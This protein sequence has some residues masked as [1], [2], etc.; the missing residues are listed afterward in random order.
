VPVAGLVGLE[1]SYSYSLMAVGRRLVV[2]RVFCAGWLV[3]SFF[4]GTYVRAFLAC[5]VAMVCEFMASSS[6]AGWFPDPVV[7]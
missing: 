2:H 4:L 5:D 1:Y 6:C 3:L 7:F